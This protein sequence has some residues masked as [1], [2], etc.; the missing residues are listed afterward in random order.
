MISLLTDVVRNCD[1]KRVLLGAQ[2]LFK[3]FASQSRTWSLHSLPFRAE[4]TSLFGA[5]FR[6]T[7]SSQSQVL[8]TECWVEFLPHFTLSNH[9]ISSNFISI[10]VALQAPITFAVVCLHYLLPC[11]QLVVRKRCLLLFNLF[12]FSLYSILSKSVPYSLVSLVAR[13]FT[14][15]SS[16]IS[17]SVL[18]TLSFALHHTIQVFHNLYVLP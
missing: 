9:L 5:Q 16:T 3:F 7:S 11:T 4:T 10:S 1:A 17:S 2:L 8:D 18:V 6:V 15:F 13:E 14:Y 12:W